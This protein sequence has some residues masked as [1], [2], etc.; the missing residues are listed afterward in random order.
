MMPE[1]GFPTQHRNH[2]M[3]LLIGALRERSD[4]ARVESVTARFEDVT[5]ELGGNVSE[6]MQI[7]KSISDLKGYAETIT[8]AEAR[9]DVTQKSLSR[10]REVAQALADNTDLLSTN[11]STN[12]FENL[13]AQAREEFGSIVSALNVHFGG[14]AL[15]SGDDS[16][17]IAVLDQDATFALGVPFLEGATSVTVAYNNIISEFTTAG[18]T[19]DTA[20]YQGGSGDAP[21]ALVAA[22]ESVSY[23]V[24]ADEAPLR[25]VMANVIARGAAFDQTNAIPDDQRNELASLASAGLRSDISGIIAT[26]G[27]VG[28]AEGRIAT[29]KARNIASDAS[30]TV[31]FNNL[32]GADQLNA[33]IEITELERQLETAFATTARMSNL[34][35][36][37][38]L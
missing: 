15:F 12:D 14:R 30:L 13:S 25:T 7:E 29:V 3:S 9:A 1:F 20:I 21:P 31:A 23:S 4:A 6:L 24:K 8:L 34:S 32:A 16:S 35:L 37:N 11:G 38:F 10:I 2:S 18:A 27:R 36:V 28:A 5:A 19:Y 26:E 33:A 17:G 22:G